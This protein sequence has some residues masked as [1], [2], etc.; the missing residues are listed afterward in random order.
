MSAQADQSM[1]FKTTQLNQGWPASRERAPCRWQAAKPPYEVWR[2]SAPAGAHRLAPDHPRQA[3]FSH[4]PLDSAACDRKAL[5]H[6]L[7]PD[8]AHAIHTEV[9]G[10]HAGD[11]RLENLLPLR[12]RR[13]P[14]R[15]LSLRDVLAVGGWGDRQDATDRG[16]YIER[17]QIYAKVLPGPP[18][19]ASDEAALGRKMAHRGQSID[20]RP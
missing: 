19:R 15:I 17:S 5:A 11:F 2:Q 1:T 18:R 16:R 8:L 13:Q 12:P 10:K 6:H 4:Q 14:R 9:F 7:A 20:N 3:H